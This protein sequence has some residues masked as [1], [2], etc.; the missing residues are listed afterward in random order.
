MAFYLLLRLGLLLARAL[1]FRA[2]AA[3][4]AGLGR[5]AGLFLHQRYAVRA[6][7]SALAEAG[8]PRTRPGR[9]FAAYGRYWGELLSLAVRPERFDELSI[10]IEG[11]E[12]LRPFLDDEPACMLSAHMG[13]WDLL[14][15]WGARLRPGTVCLAE[16]LDPP[17]LFELF[18]EMRRSLGFEILAAEGSGRPLMRHFAQGGTAGLIADRVIG[19]GW[20]EADF[21]GGRRRLPS[22]G[23]DIA[24]RSGAA[25][26]PI[27][28]LRRDGGYVIKVHPP[29]AGTEDPV[30]VYARVLEKEALAQPDQWCLMAPLHDAARNPASRSAAAP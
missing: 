18:R 4:C 17:R 26:L 30:Q 19:A 20:R 1:S 24:R 29:L 15:Q 8:A 11:E 12:H 6:N 3:L 10:E 16:R 2:M 28:L 14:A 5:L 23:M 21:L 22:A 27:F 7:L 25:L 9:V 13:N